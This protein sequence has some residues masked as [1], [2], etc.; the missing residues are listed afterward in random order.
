MAFADLHDGVITIKTEFRDKDIIRS[1]PGATYNA[2]EYVWTVPLSWPGCLALRG[3]FGDRLDV[4]PALNEWAGNYRREFVAPALD[5]RTATSADGDQDLYPFQRA[6]VRWMTHVRRGILTDEMGTGKTVQSIRT[7][8]SVLQNVDINPF[9]ALIVAPNSM[10]QTWQ[11]EFARWWPGVQA[12]ILHGGRVQRAKQIAQMRDGN[13]HVLITNWESLR[14]HSRLAPYGSIFLKRCVKCDLS[15]RDVVKQAE[16]DAATAQEAVDTLS[17]NV[18]DDD[19]QRVALI[20]A[21]TEAVERAKK[22][23][24]S[25]STTSCERCPRDLNEIPWT[26]IFADEAHRAKEPTAKQTRALW[27]LRTDAT[28]IRFPLTGTPIADTPDDY[29]SLLHFIDEKAWPV[30]SKWVDRYCLQSF[31]PFGGMNIVGLKPETRNEFFASTDPY[32]RRMPKSLVLSQLPPKVY[33][34]RHVDMSPKQQRAY[35]AM[36]KDMIARLDDTGAGERLV[37]PDPL[38]QL[39]RL[40]QFASSYAELVEVE[41]RDPATGLMVVKTEVR[42]TDP[43]NKVDELV[44]ILEEVRG[45]PIGVFAQSRQLIE[46]ASKRLEKL[47]IRHGLIVGGQTVGERQY[48]I[49][50]FQRGELPAVLATVG[51]GGVGITLTRADTCVFMQR[52]WS[53]I[54]NAQA[55]D[56]FHRIGSEIHE[57]IQIIDLISPGTIEETQRLSL[58]AKGDRM[59]E[60]TRDADIL[61]RALD[62]ELGI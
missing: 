10:K 54:E 7:L 18:P 1:V 16:D 19:P 48:S 8:V 50:R 27:A 47:G 34:T 44:E 3:L 52:S 2:R 41:V 58:S 30:R 5:M 31:N 62:A 23:A 35:A 60:V 25:H 22:L 55:E 15:L 49:D 36:K 13:A 57:S 32:I 20:T 29:W 40:S 43:S 38:V 37:A 46:L 12:V 24:R 9:P 51:A 42:L 33:T 4:G 21:L 39:T 6:G 26:T 17:E 28:K 59:Q 61:R 45:K 56:R 53:M 11:N 14:G